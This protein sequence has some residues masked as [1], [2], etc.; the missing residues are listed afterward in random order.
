MPQYVLEATSLSKTYRR[1]RRSVDAVKDV[2]LSIS[3]GEFAAV[4]GPS[5]CGKST[6]LYLLGGLTRPTDGEVLMAGRLT[7]A[8]SDRE[9]ALLRQRHVGFVFQRFNLMP[10]LSARANVELPLRIRGDGR[11]SR[12]EVSAL[13]ER[14]GLAEMAGRRPSELSQ[15][16]EQRV[17][18]ARAIV[19]NPDILFADEPTGNLDSENA[20]LVL[21]LMRELN[22]AGQTVVLVTHD[23]EAARYASR[24]IRMKDARIVSA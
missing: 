12:R 10:A 15:G 4:V 7:A 16:E 5:G 18:I 8:L 21:E 17:A 19:H 11:A 2:D 23:A 13:L 6:L 14:V 22:D 1:G 24:T 9:L 20:R 3:R